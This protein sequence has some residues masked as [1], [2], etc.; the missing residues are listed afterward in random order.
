MISSMKNI[1]ETGDLI[2]LGKDTHL[3]IGVVIRVEKTSFTDDYYCRIY[4]S[5]NGLTTSFSVSSLN[6]QTDNIWTAT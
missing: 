4:W 2:I 3:L 1:P 6:K 5:D